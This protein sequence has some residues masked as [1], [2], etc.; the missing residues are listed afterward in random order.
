MTTSE[1]ATIAKLSE[2]ALALLRD[3]LGPS[4]YIALLSENKLYKDAVKFYA[5][6]MPPKVAIN[7]GLMCSKEL[8]DPATE[9]KRKPSVT[10][11]EN[12]LKTPEDATRWEAKKVADK[13]GMETSADCMAM[14]VFFSGGS[15]TPPEKNAPEVQPAPYMSNKF[16]AGGIEIAVV[17]FEPA[18]KEERFQKALDLGRAQ[19]Q[20]GSAPA[21]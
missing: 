19:L 4:K 7:W 10:A 18:K 8:G 5:H 1:L 20:G 3:D 17:S 6:G 16:V 15:I 2:P 12:W 14:A 9:E 11:V 21:S 13:S